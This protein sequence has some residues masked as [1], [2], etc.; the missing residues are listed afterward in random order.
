[1]PRRCCPLRAHAC[2]GIRSTTIKNPGARCAPARSI[3]RGFPPQVTT[4][5]LP[6]SRPTSA[7]PGQARSPNY[8][9]PS[10]RC[11]LRQ[12]AVAP[13]PVPARSRQRHPGNPWPWARPSAVPGAH[14]PTCG[15]D[16]PRSRNPPTPSSGPAVATL[17]PAC[18][19]HAN[20]WRMLLPFPC[21]A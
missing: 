18:T 8:P 2:A 12:D 15:R 17:A 9:G 6:P 13:K 11:L 7:R 3:S 20:I 1:M 14:S 19:R 21:G 4:A 16:R 5:F 10:Q